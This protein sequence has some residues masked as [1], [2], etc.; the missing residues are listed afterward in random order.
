LKE[1]LKKVGGKLE[2]G[3]AEFSY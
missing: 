3:P 1:N 2:W